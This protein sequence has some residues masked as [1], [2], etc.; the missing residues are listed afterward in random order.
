M[1]K[2]NKG[3]E[4]YMVKISTCS[5]L[6]M[7]IAAVFFI[8]ACAVGGEVVKVTTVQEGSYA[9]LKK[10]DLSKLEEIKK[11]SGN[12][13]ISDSL[14]NVIEETRHF[15]VAQYLMQRPEARG[16]AGGD[17]RVGGYDVLSITVYEEK[18]LS[19]GAVRVSADGY[20]S[21]PLIGRIK[22]DDVAT[23]EIEKLISLKLAE[24]QYVLDAHV[25]VMV[26]EYN[27]K[28]FLVLGA[29]KNPGSYP[30]QARE[31]V[32]DAISKAGG[33]DFDQ[34]GKKGMIIRTQS[35]NVEQERKIVINLDLHGLLKGEDQV[36]NIFLA[37]KDVLFIPT[38]EH[39]YIIGQVSK[40]GSYLLADKEITLVG[41]ISTAGGFT[42]IAAR[43]RTRI[44]RVEDGVDKIIE[45][46]V[47]AITDAGKKIH[48]VI[49]QPDDVIVVPESFF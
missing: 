49:I 7:T 39:F 34:A 46:K 35:A 48:D 22:V 29:V 9:G 32:L 13:G 3:K 21:F 28:R 17:Y 2:P 36:S 42:P 14:R 44:V 23:S 31:R 43:N 26:T 12:K 20:I 33:I 6:I 45:V 1:R 11:A 25:S 8:A 5:H 30:L 24:E 27:S 10:E 41:A 15:S 38:A 47:D 19:R 4:S 37:N 16:L 40:P 18:D